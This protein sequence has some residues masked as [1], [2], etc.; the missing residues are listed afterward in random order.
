MSR[1]APL[2]NNARRRAAIAVELAPRPSGRTL[3]FLGVCAAITA[4]C[5]FWLPI[6]S[7]A[8]MR[9]WAQ[10]FG[11]VGLLV[12]LA[13]YAIITVTPVP[14][15]IFTLASGLLY[16]SLLGVAVSVTASTLAAVLAFL[17][18]RRIAGERV[19][20]YIRHP[21]AK[22]VQQQLSQR[23]WLAVWSV[24]L[25][26]PVPFALQ[27]YLCGV[28]TVRLVPYT[29]ASFMGLIPMTT[30]VVL[31]GDAT[32]GHFDPKFFLVSACCITVGLVGLAIN[33]RLSKADDAQTDDA[34]GQRAAE[35][36]V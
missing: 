20:S 16:G 35:E 6:P 26:A 28:S 15:T 33:A 10:S 22:H 30:A 14:R 5:V 3:A 4:A 21:L 24:R 25:I 29:L 27:N 31:L 18:A 7:P 32:T 8:V 34:L 1:W 2:I 23:G 17:F 9:D 11:A 13:A 36:E 12:F 19:Q